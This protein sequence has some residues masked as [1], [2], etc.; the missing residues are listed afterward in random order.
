ML[1]RRHRTGPYALA[2]T[3]HPL[4]PLLSAAMG[5][6]VLVLLFWALKAVLSVFEFG[7]AIAREAVILA[8]SDRGSV[9]VSLS[10]E[11]PRLA[12]ADLK[13]YPED[14]VSTDRGAPA[15][16]SFFDGT[17]LRMD[18]GGQIMIQESAQGSKRSYL[19]TSLDRGTL[20]VKTPEASA[21]SG[22]IV[23]TL[24]TLAF[25]AHIP[26]GAEVLFT[27]DRIE[28]YS[29][30][31]VGVTISMRSSANPII[32]GE[33]QKFS[34]PQSDQA[35]SDPYQF[36][37]PIVDAPSS[38]V[39]ESRV[40]TIPEVEAKPTPGMSDEPLTVLQPSEGETLRSATITVKGA[41][42]SAIAMVR[43]NG[44]RASLDADKGTYSIEIAP[45][46]QEEVTL[47]I[48]G[49][50]EDG[51][52]LAKITRTVRRD[53]TP[54]TTPTI[55]QPSANGTTYRTSRDTVEIRGTAPRGTTGII[56]N[57][58]RLQLFTEGDNEWSYLASTKLQNFSQGENV[59][60]VVA[61]NAT[62][63]RSDPAVLT[64]IL[65]EGEEGVVGAASNGSASSAKPLS[66]AALP[67]N[68][69]LKPGTLSVH[70]PSAGTQHT[71][72][73]SGTG[74]ELLIEGSVPPG[75]QSMWVND[76][77]LRLY[78]P[79][80]TFFNYIAST[81]LNTLKRGENPY[82]IVARDKEGMILDRMTYT[83][84]VTRE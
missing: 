22:S 59:F 17:E 27:Q 83:I 10:G 67:K 63:L 35:V 45:P 65:G 15:S 11:E 21:F 3:R 49:L 26:S 60:R 40:R 53:R 5:I 8:V 2:K 54:P 58:Y 47:S 66:L 48:E 82:V 23:R 74:L 31:G 46:D 61:I 64:I 81:A 6:V 51:T 29:A 50:G 13:L 4:V 12:D 56:V 7:N 76:Y 62:G 32:V 70:A 84:T 18:K 9:S 43:V 36:R 16:L 75:T 42:H 1:R 33:G 71:A 14:T 69:P 79:G 28:V 57:D 20:W 41:Y 44:Y 34:V 68:D 77:Q 25:E 73:L 38:F 80:K 24:H 39:L 37:S 72:M 30:D 78:S 19:E 55:L 52:L